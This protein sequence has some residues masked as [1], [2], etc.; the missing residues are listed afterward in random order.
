MWHFKIYS[1]TGIVDEMIALALDRL[2]LYHV[3]FDMK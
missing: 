2:R 1:V 3:P